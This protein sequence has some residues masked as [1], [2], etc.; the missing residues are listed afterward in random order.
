MKTSQAQD[1]KKSLSLIIKRVEESKHE[2]IT[3]VNKLLI[4]LYWF[5]G[6][7]I[8][9]L[10]EKSK[11][12][13]GVVEKLSQDL[14]MKYPEMKGFSVQNLWYMKKFYLTY[15]GASIL[16]TLSGEISWSNNVLILD[17]TK[18]I[19]EKE[20]YLKMCI[21]ERWSYRELQRQ[22][23]S[24]YFE[25]FMLSQK[26]D[27][28]VKIEQEKLAIPLDD[29]YRHL[30]D[31][32]I[33]E[34]LDLSE[35]FSEKELR[36]AILNNLRD[37]F[38]E[39]GKN[40]SFVGDEYPLVV[41][42]EEFRIDLLFFHRELKCLIAI[43]LKIGEFKPEYVG[44]MQFYLAAL[45]EQ[46]K[47]PHENPSVGLILC[48]SKKDS[49]VRLTLSKIHEPVKISIYQTK[50]PDKKLIQQRLERIKL[51]EKLLFNDSMS[52]VRL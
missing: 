43:E 23:D 30:K 7:T 31:E 41:D 11:W 29:I 5:I 34:F 27:K 1:Y 26:P 52:Y 14:R 17:K 20:F 37:F 47:L 4:E 16:Q 10:Q 45:D 19:E 28:L 42:G 15:R 49:V 33:L 2:A 18:S 8:I 50:L 9:N 36:K 40:L 25:R 46:I 3:T 12:G 44:K 13:D 51:P 48:R 21:K 32:Y 38:L 35:T 24:A 39:F 6:G 22:V